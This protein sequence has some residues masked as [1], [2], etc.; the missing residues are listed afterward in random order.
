MSYWHWLVVTS[1][2]FILLERVFP[3]RGGQSVFRHSWLRDA[4]FLALNGHF[5]SLWTAALTGAAALGAS[6]G[7]RAVGLQLEG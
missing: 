4:A 3:W 5:F 6:K 1:L 2:V 7:L